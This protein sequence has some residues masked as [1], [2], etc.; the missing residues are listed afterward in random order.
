MRRALPAVLALLCGCTTLGPMPAITGQSVVPTPRPGG[1][2][3]VAAVP[4]YYL[5]E[6]VQEQPRGAAIQQAAVMLEPGDLIGLPGLSVGGRFVGDGDNG[7]FP[8]P[9]VRYR[10]HVDRQKMLAV[11]GVVYGGYG[12]GS[13]SGASYEATR[14]G[15]EAA[16]DLRATPRSKWVEVH[17]FG[18]LGLMGLDA[19]GDYCLDA[20]GRW[21]VD[22]DDPPTTLT[23]AKASGFYPTAAGGIALDLARH[24]HGILHGGRVALHGAVGRMPHVEGAEQKSAKT[25]TS[26]GL[27]VT[28]GMGAA[29]P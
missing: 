1:E 3:Q 18:S 7:G 4:G 25:F 9:M 24:L 2:A 20:D 27:S 6:S 11:G 12:H 17:L 26:A 5:S 28:L 21:G 23:H 16:L 8:E 14:G 22:C 19:N 13:A 29:E 10:A 15:A